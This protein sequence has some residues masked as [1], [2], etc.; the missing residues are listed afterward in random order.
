VESPVSEDSRGR[1][2]GRYLLFDAIARGGMA[3][4]H[5][6]RLSGAV[7]FSRTVAIKRLHPHLATDPEFVAMFLDEARLASRIRHPNVVP[8]LDVAATGGEVFIVLEYVPGEALSRL[9]RSRELRGE[10][11]PI[12]YALAI[13]AGVLHGLHAAHEVTDEQ[14]RPLDIVHRDVS[15]Q[16]ILVGTDGVARVLDFGVAKAANR[17][18]DTG[19]GS[20]KGKI[21]YMAPEQI[22]GGQVTRQTDIHAASVV[23]WELLVGRRLVEGENDAARAAM[24]LQSIQSRVFAPPSSANPEVSRELDEIV[25]RGLAWPPSE[26]FATA[27]E[28]ATVLEKNGGLVPTSEIGE[29]VTRE[30][31]RALTQRADLL[32]AIEASSTTSKAK[33]RAAAAASGSS[34]IT[35]PDTEETILSD[36]PPFTAVQPAKGRGRAGIAIVLALLGV[37]LGVGGVFLWRSRNAPVM[38]APPPPTAPATPRASTSESAPIAVGAGVDGDRDY[39]RDQQRL[40]D[41]THDRSPSAP[42]RVHASRATAARLRPALHDRCREPQG[43]QA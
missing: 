12:R 24:I 17:L 1:A 5:F 38:A 2:L 41:A 33:M 37:N 20:L 19:E 23:L 22:A 6:A 43:L 11:I 21:A 32:Q 31:E 27:K 10:R 3:T 4:V 25:L 35:L 9:W 8:T 28:M 18:Q 34:Q 36:P 39:D 30:A 15:P 40:A 14:G 16:N 7:G 26:R 42:A 13:I 29:W